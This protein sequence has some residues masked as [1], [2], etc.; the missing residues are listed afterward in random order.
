MTSKRKSNPDSAM[1]SAMRRYQRFSGHRGELI[2]RLRPSSV[3]G[4]LTGDKK[5]VVIA[6]GT[7]DFVGYTT[8]RD[9]KTESYIHRFA[10]SARPLLASSHDGRSLLI[11]GGGYRFT[12]RGIVDTTRRRR[13]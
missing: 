12:E 2:A 5:A 6:I 4:I 10:S 7:L 1:E 9:G 3:R 8:K 13:I 11:L